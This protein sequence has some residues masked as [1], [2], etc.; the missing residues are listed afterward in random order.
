MQGLRIRNQKAIFL[1]YALS[2]NRLI[3]VKKTYAKC[4]LDS[5]DATIFLLILEV[6]VP[7]LALE[8]FR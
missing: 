8:Q 4:T 6:C 1:R 3:G 5:D 7:N 2:K